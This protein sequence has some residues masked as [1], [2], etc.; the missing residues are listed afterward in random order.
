[1]SRMQGLEASGTNLRTQLAAQER[2][3]SGQLDDD[4]EAGRGQT[5]L[6]AR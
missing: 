6:Q 1:M 5:Q 3:L 4:I 2:S